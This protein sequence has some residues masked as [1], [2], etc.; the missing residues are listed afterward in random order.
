MNPKQKSALSKIFAL[1][2]TVLLWAPIAFMLVTAVVVGI[3][4]GLF[5]LDFLMLAELLPIIALGLILL[6]LAGI[7][8]RSYIKWFGWGTGAALASLAGGQLLAVASGLASGAAPRSG[9]AFGVVIASIA[10]YN[11]VVVALA[12]LGI[13][14]VKR[15]FRKSPDASSPAI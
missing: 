14:L 3:E 10:V 1:S 5:N 4:S 7:L 12:V 6:I 15:L 11:L 2:G 8:S 13:S 9:L